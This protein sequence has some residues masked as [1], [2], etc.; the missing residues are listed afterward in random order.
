MMCTTA[1]QQLAL[2]VKNDL[3]PAESASVRGHMATCFDC[4]QH[5]AALQVAMNALDTFK[6]EQLEVSPRS[7]LPKLQLALATQAAR[8]PAESRWRAAFRNT[9]VPT[10]IGVAM[11]LIGIQLPESSPSLPVAAPYDG[12]AAAVSQRVELD[13]LPP[14]FVPVYLEPSWQSLERLDRPIGDRR[15]LRNVSSY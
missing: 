9:L 6:T 1:R 5:F 2:L 15:S 14:N 13:G 8:E 7:V 12:H 3:P 4:Q 11:F 10:L